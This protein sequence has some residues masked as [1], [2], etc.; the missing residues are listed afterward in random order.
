MKPRQHLNGK[1]E[2][3]VKLYL[4][5]DKNLRGYPVRCYKAAYGQTNDRCAQVS[6]SRLLQNPLI[7]DLVSKAQ[8][9]ANQK[10]ILDASFVLTESKRLYDRAMGDEPIPGKTTITKDPE[11]GQERVTSTE[12]HEYDPATARQALQMIGQHKSVQA[13]SVQVEHSHTH[14]LEQRLAARSKVIEASAG[15]VG[16]DPSLVGVMPATTKAIAAQEEAIANP[17]PVKI[18]RQRVPS[19][20]GQSETIAD[21]E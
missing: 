3:F 6:A 8:A 10:I 9:R 14:I 17:E 1:Q 5:K 13:F 4:G 12:R 2:A 11:T 16:L 19:S 7:K 18:K 21:E 20:G 15:Q